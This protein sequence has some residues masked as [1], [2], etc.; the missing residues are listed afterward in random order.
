MQTPPTNKAK[1]N[2]GKHPS[3][4]QACS[5][6]QAPRRC[7][8]AIARLKRAFDKADGVARALGKRTLLGAAL[9]LAFQL[10]QLGLG[11]GV[12]L[13]LCLGL[14]LGVGLPLGLGL[15]LCGNG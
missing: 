11:L 15:G 7:N 10:F 6:Q 8:V 2:E 5:P 14:G 9:A 13:L 1:R 3:E 12:A 4:Q